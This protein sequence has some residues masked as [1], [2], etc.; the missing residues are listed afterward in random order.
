VARRGGDYRN[1]SDDCSDLLPDATA[2]NEARGPKRNG[3]KTARGR[4]RTGSA[5]AVGASRAPR[6]GAR[7]SALEACDS[8]PLLPLPLIL[9]PFIGQSRWGGPVAPVYLGPFDRRQSAAQRRGSSTLRTTRQPCGTPLTNDGKVCV[10]LLI[11]RP[12]ICFI[13]VEI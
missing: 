5:V 1:R 3:Q 13:C 7:L 11:L 6:G 12:F 8:V 10:F 9:R 2:L 4:H